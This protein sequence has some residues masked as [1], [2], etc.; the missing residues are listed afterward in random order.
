VLRQGLIVLQFTIAVALI[1][2]TLTVYK[3][4]HFLR[5]QELGFAEDQVLYLRAVPPVADQFDVFRQQLVQN[6][7]IVQATRTNGVPGR[8][9]NQRGYFWVNASGEVENEGLYTIMT[10]AYFVETLGLTI[11][12]GRDFDPARPGDVGATYIVNEAAV[13]RL[14]IDEPLGH[15]I[16]VWDQDEMGQIVGVVEDFHFKSLHQTVEPVV[17]NL[18]PWASYI[19]IR[20]I[21]EQ[22]PQTIVF[23]QDQWK[24]LAPAF[25]FDYVFLDEDFDRLYLAEDQLMKRFSFFAFIAIFISCL[26]L[27]GLAAYSAEQRIKEIGVRKVLGASVPGIISLLSRDFLKLVV[28]AFF[29]AA[30][31]AFFGMTRWLEAFAF[32]TSLGVDTFTIAFATAVAI[33]FLTVFYQSIRAALSNPVDALHYE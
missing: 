2:G 20:V 26:G 4:L 25:P 11:K 24:E 15:P 3:Q 8:L 29:I 14:G 16:R 9:T 32:R 6:P 23:I 17:I 22:L 27:F 7:R 30:P 31:L 28:I 13:R 18:T 10:D 33:A 19:A 1:I 5:A 21:P 12:E